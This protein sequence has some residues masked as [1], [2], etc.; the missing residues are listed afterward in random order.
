MPSRLNAHSPSALLARRVLRTQLGKLRSAAAAARGTPTTRGGVEGVHAMRVAT[1]RTRAALRLFRDDLPARRPARL[2]EELKWL[3]ASLGAVR[4]LDVL[5]AAL[6]GW[7][8]Q[9]PKQQRSGWDALLAEIARRRTGAH[10]ALL[11]VLESRRYE[12]LLEGV[13]A[14]GAS[15]L[16][17]RDRAAGA[18]VANTAPRRLHRQYQHLWTLARRV[19]P[20][21]ATAEALHSLRIRAKRLR[22]AMEFHEPMLGPTATALVPRLV[23]L[24]D[25]LGAHQDA[26]VA[27]RRL[28]G[29]AAACSSP[30]SPPPAAL[31]EP[32]A[33]ALALYGRQATQARRSLP[34][35]L[36]PLHPA[37]WRRARRGFGGDV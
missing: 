10:R 3:A 17:A 25:V 15:P 7:R 2:R 9:L 31:A 33:A 29:I 30:D 14:L 21:T 23:A 37:A 22:Y 35:A 8:S 4:D 6:R 18:R 28:Q 16:R 24:Q 5:I 20:R 13:Q 34:A 27:R 11:R 36:R 32:L 26:I 1:R 19:R 12:R